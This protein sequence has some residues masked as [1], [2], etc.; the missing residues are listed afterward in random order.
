MLWSTLKKRT[1]CYQ[2][3]YKNHLKYIALE[4]QWCVL[5]NLGLARSAEWS[6]SVCWCQ[7]L[8]QLRPAG[9]AVG[10]GASE[11]T[12]H[13]PPGAFYFVIISYSSPSF[14]IEWQLD[15][16][17]QTASALKACLVVMLFDVPLAKSSHTGKP[18]VSVEGD[19]TSVWKNRAM[20]H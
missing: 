4:Q 17:P 10:A 12:S 2:L 16:K 15:I 7:S 8:T 11:T 6:S 20:Y 13:H 1:G 14:S 18:R 19:N 5:V 3:Q 9:R